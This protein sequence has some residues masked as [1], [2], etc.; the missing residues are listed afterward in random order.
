MRRPLALLS[1]A[2]VLGG[3]ATFGP[4][5]RGEAIHRNVVYAVRSGKKLHVDL[6]VPREAKPVPVIVWLHGGGWKYGDKGYHLSIRNLT[7]E[8]FAIASVQ[9]RL[10][11][12]APWPAQVID[13]EEAV[14]WIRKDGDRYGIDP[15]RLALAG[16]SAGGHLAALI[17][18]RETRRNV[19]AVLAMYPPTDLVVMGRRYANYGRLSIFS[20]MF[21]GEIAN[22]RAEAR[23]ASPVTYA[24][25]SSPPFLIFHGDKDW[26]VPPEQSE[27]LDA[28][29]R[30]AGVES[31]LVIVKGKG[32][33]F[34]LDQSQLEQVAA[35]F[36]KHL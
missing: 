36:R 2:T 14:D 29:L 27:T 8:G 26:L 25:R 5:R 24:S 31:K 20:Q 28:A 4:A 33:A 21:D 22:R 10:L 17:G 34:G 35:F 19:K 15:S 9:Y 16:E 11:R 13:C 18:T 12:N 23:A 32:H 1:L 6:Y 30:K 7:R 3:C